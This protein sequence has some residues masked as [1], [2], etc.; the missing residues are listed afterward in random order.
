MSRCKHDDVKHQN[1][2]EKDNNVK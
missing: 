1:K 2:S